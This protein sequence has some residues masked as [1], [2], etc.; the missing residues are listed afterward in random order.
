MFVLI[1]E[2][3]SMEELE[4]PEVLRLLCEIDDMIVEMNRKLDAQARDAERKCELND[5]TE[6]RRKLSD[7]ERRYLLIERLFQRYNPNSED[8]F[9]HIPFL[10]E[11][12][13]RIH[14]AGKPKRSHSSGPST[15]KAKRIAGARSRKT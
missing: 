11:R 3:Q 10:Q 1:L 5:E 15:A 6:Y 14:R 2:K 13:S 12:L 8:F 7:G 4:D 9:D